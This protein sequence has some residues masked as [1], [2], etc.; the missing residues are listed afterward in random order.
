M[1]EDEETIGNR[2]EK[3]WK[4]LRKITLQGKGSLRNHLLSIRMDAELTQTLRSLL[5]NLSCFAN[6]RNG[7]WYTSDL[8]DDTCY[9]KSTDGHDG[10]WLFSLSRM[11]LNVAIAAQKKKGCLIVDSTKSGKRFPD[12]MYATIPIWCAVLNHVCRG[13]DT[14]SNGELPDFF[15][16]S[17]I[18]SSSAIRM[19]QR[20]KDIISGLSPALCTQIRSELCSSH[21][22][23][24]L[25]MRPVW[26]SVE[27]GCFQW[28]GYTITHGDGED[29][30]EEVLNALLNSDNHKKTLPFAPLVL[31]S[32]SDLARTRHNHAVHHSWDYI[33]GAGDDEEA[34]RPSPLFNATFFW[35]HV[36]EILASD[37]PDTVRSTVTSLL[38]TEAQLNNSK[39]VISTLSYANKEHA[40]DAIGSSGLWIGSFDACYHLS[41][42]SSLLSITSAIVISSDDS[43]TSAP[44]NDMKRAG[45][46]ILSINALSIEKPVRQY[47]EKDLLPKC[48]A[49]AKT[50]KG[51]EELAIICGDGY[52]AAPVIAIAILLDQ[53]VPT[54]SLSSFQKG[55]SETV[56]KELIRRVLMQLQSFRPPINPPRVLMKELNSY[57]MSRKL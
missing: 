18:P 31:F 43:R 5:P 2:Y 53:T 14:I 38:E 28:E 40:L 39:A 33:A 54:F 27:D 35:A 29:D 7:R 8:P 44:V 20:I 42:K 17:W 45:A 6:L 36:D 55:E 37:C 41:D 11:N 3:E 9:F 4:S 32:C 56:N 23:N 22:H 12:S 25:P 52:R 26:V 51:D 34:W 19:R 49:W 16:P 13:D 15:A 10:Q 47:W 57:F 50:L 24:F 46:S 48:V 21:R 30:M 1:S